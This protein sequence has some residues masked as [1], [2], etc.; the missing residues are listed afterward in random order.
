MAN[1]FYVDMGYTKT[2]IAT[3]SK[4]Y[5]VVMTLL[6]AFIGGSLSVRF[7]VMRVLLWG[8][9]LSALSNLLFSWLSLYG[10]DVRALI[11]VISMDNL[12]GGIA[13]AAFIAY[14]SSLVN[15]EY[16]ATQYA[17]LSSVMLLIPKFLAGFSGVFVN[18]FGYQ[19]FFIA[20]AF[21]GIP[22]ILLILVINKQKPE[23]FT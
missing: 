12:S 19:Y 2:E 17:I 7:G 15:I 23:H 14:L 20:T 22:V 21:L 11:G 18:H 13:S 4:V 1:P 10:H 6:G 16:S 3:V 5:G 9:I 8:A